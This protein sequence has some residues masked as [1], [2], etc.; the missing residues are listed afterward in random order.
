MDVKTMKKTNNNNQS[1]PQPRWFR[2]VARRSSA[3]EIEELRDKTLLINPGERMHKVVILEFDDG[4]TAKVLSKIRDEDG[5]INVLVKNRRPT[6]EETVSTSETWITEE[7][8][9]RFIV[10]LKK[11]Q[12][13]HEVLNIDSEQIRRD[14]VWAGHLMKTRKPA[15]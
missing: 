10:V 13:V 11:D 2:I 4:N 3:Q 5:R 9:E 12:N 6:G 1:D 15:G 14:V 7:D 8:Y